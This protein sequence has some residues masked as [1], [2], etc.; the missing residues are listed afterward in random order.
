MVWFKKNTE[1]EVVGHFNI[2]FDLENFLTSAD[3]LNYSKREDD[4]PNKSR[5]FVQI[6]TDLAFGMDK[7][8]KVRI[9]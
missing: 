1:W 4:N 9:K 5:D 7:T 3:E 6:R 8:G 2:V